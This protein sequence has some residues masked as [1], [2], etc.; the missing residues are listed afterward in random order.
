MQLSNRSQVREALEIQLSKPAEKGKS[1]S[2]ADTGTQWGLGGDH[3]E[4]KKT[5]PT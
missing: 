2:A 4:E 1:S 5:L 3:E